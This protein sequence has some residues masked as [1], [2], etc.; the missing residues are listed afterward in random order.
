M[1]F[2]LY[3][4]CTNSTSIFLADLSSDPSNLAKDRCYCLGQLGVIMNKWESVKLIQYFCGRLDFVRTFHL[5]KLQFIRRIS[6]F[7]SRSVVTECV[8]YYSLSK[9][10]KDM[11][12]VFCY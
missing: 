11:V 10:F 3:K 8:S 2:S 5:R 4:F 1:F 12:S 9:E 7:D 6:S